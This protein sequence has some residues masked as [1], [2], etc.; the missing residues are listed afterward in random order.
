MR[1]GVD[2]TPLIGERTGIG[3]YTAGLLEGLRALG[4]V[5][6]VLTA[7]T[8]RGLEGLQPFAGPDRRLAPRR[9][10]ARPLQA[11][12]RRV[13]LPVVEALAGPLEAFHATNYVLPPLR[14]AAGV[15]S[16]HDLSFLD[17]ADTVAPAT[18]A[19]RSLVPRGIARA[20]AIAV[21]TDVVGKA[22]AERYGVPPER[23]VVAAPGVDDAWFDARPADDSWLAERG[24]PRDY[25]LF[26]GTTQPRK[27]LPVLV[28]AHQRLG[29]TAPPLVLAGP[30]G[31]GPA[32]EERGLRRAGYLADDE[33]RRLVAGASCLVLPSRDEGFGLPALEAL[34]CGIP[35][36]ASDLPVL[37]EV[38][39]SD[40]RFAT[41][42]DP[43]ALAEA[44]GGALGEDAAGEAERR[45]A[46]ARRFTWRACAAAAMSAYELARS[47]PPIGHRSRPARRRRPV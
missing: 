10:P 31:W 30:A 26:V 33:L 20:G 39:G 40:A 18:L 45:R 46:R 29:P 12:W 9:A 1:L 44:L 41:V 23:I 25:A 36:V 6:V 22:V 15:L 32:L 37:R 2:A 21:L 24:L 27:N 34:A 7:F 13:D 38:L 43:A 19:Y 42:G 14:A 4:G 5:E 47:A 28:A 35:V 3:R 11:L 17:H 8:W 16:I